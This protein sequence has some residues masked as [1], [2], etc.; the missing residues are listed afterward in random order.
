MLNEIDMLH[1][2]FMLLYVFDNT[3][4][5][6]YEIFI[7]RAGTPEDRVFFISLSHAHSSPSLQLHYKETRVHALNYNAG[8]GKKSFHKKLQIHCS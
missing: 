2:P 3:K 4:I 8:T 1:L 6:L 5:F 7:F